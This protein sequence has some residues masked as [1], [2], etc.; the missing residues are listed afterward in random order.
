MEYEIGAEDDDGAMLGR[1]DATEPR[2]RDVC[3]VQMY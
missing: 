3:I 2:I 1:M